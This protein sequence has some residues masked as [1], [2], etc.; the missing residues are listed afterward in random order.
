M[1]H[2]FRKNQRVMMFVVAVLTIIAFIWLYNPDTKT[3]NAGPNSVGEIYGRNL[4]QADIDNVQEHG[5]SILVDAR[6]LRREAGCPYQL[7]Q[8]LN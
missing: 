5:Q 6:K 4:T 3:G 2:I 8:I 7:H 1:I